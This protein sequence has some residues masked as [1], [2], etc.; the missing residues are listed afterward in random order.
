MNIFT[1]FLVADLLGIKKKHM[2]YIF[3]E[4]EP[5][6]FF[7]AFLL[8]IHEL[9][10][11]QIFKIDSHHVVPQRKYCKELGHSCWVPAIIQN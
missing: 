10:L 3:C 7:F 5:N 4:R 9:N 11:L 8:I 6:F 1:Y 2:Q